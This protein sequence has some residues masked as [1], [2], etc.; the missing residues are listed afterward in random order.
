M[1]DLWGRWSALSR[2]W[3]TFWVS[4]AVLIVV[5]IVSNAAALIPLAFLWAAGAAT[6][7]RLRDRFM[8]PD[9]EPRDRP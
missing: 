9:E 8:P 2:P 4:S 7:V 3:K 5:F 1:G 6:I